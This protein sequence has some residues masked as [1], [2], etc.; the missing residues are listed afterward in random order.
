M[1][2]NATI[3]E[4]AASA[5]SNEAGIEGYGMPMCGR[6]QGSGCDMPHSQPDQSAIGLGAI[7]QPVG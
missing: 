5:A 3:M 6:A 2:R 4:S 7:D 1:L